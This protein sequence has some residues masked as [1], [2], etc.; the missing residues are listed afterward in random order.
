MAKILKFPPG[1][2]WGVSTSA[3]QIEGG[4]DNDWSEWER[5]EVRRKKLKEENK[6]LSDFICGQACDSYNKYEE[7]L[8]LVKGLNCGAYRMGLE[9]ARLEP[10][11]GKFD[12]AEI[13]HYR[14]VLAAAKKRNLKVVLTLW[15]WTNPLWLTAQGGWANNQAIEYFARYVELAAREL[16]EYVDYWVTINEP[17]VYIANGYLTAKF[18]PNKKNIF[19][20]WRV[21]QNLVKAH[22]AGYGIIHEKIP[23]A[24]IGLTML[25]NYF[26]PAHKGNLVEVFSAKLADH[27]W[28]DRFV[29]KLKN[30]FD[31]LGLDYYFHDRLAWYP[32]FRKNLNKEVTDM[33]WEIYP[34]GIYQVLKNYAKFKKPLFIME[35]GLADQGDKKR[36]KFITGHLQYVHQAISEGVD[37]RGYFYWSLIDN[38]E[39]A[40]GFKPKFGLYVVDRKTFARLPR[41]SARIYSEICKNNQVRVE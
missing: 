26:E 2:L 35:N 7:D 10:E 19:Q 18:P 32:P 3:Y 17:M 6:N 4:I 9:W 13:K 27:C 25:T 34:A 8:D 12:Q 33:G 30:K 31:F 41:P 38:F 23:A 15:H 14:Q 22:R 24:K 5:T 11:Q 37:A 20:A 29:K 39:W 28:N 16:G 1:F 21:C 40:H 36:V